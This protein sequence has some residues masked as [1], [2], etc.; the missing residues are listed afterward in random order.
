[1]NA[2]LGEDKLD[3]TRNAIILAPSAAQAMRLME[4]HR[5]AVTLIKGPQI[6]ALM[7][8][9]YPVIEAKEEANVPSNENEGA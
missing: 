5:L 2:Y 8:L 6:V 7:K 4:E 1:M 9:G 3:K